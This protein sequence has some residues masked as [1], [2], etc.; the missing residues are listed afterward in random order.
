MLQYNSN[1]KIHLLCYGK[2]LDGVLILCYAI[3]VLFKIMP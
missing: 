2:I 3:N 1:C